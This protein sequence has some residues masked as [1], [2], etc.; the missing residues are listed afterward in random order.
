MAKKL[1]TIQVAAEV[2]GVSRGC[3]RNWDGCGKLQAI[4]NKNN[5]YR[6]YDI[7]K[8]QKFASANKL[9]FFNKKILKD[10]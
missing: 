8:L 9:K 5:R 7:T 1:V 2:L 3:L 6:F 4:R 10:D